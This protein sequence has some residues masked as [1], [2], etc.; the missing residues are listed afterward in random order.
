VEFPYVKGDG[1]FGPVYRPVIPVTISSGAKSFPV[2]HAL[3]DTGADMTLLPLAIAHLLEIPLDDSRTLK[4]GGA[5]GGV[6]A[7]LPSL[8]KIGFA[9]EQRGHRPIV[10]QGTAYFSPDQ[11]AVLLGHHQCLELLSLHFRGPDRMFEVAMK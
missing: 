6:F 2:G 4:V 3:V 5:G 11:P 9:I 7:A 1:G 10:W 8:R